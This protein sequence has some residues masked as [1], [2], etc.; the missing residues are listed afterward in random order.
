M[1]ILKVAAPA[2]VTAA[3]QVAVAVILVVAHRGSGDED[4]QPNDPAPKNLVTP[5]RR[6]IAEIL[7]DGDYARH[8]NAGNDSNR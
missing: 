3:T 6:S 2:M 8:A 5:D 7:D 4:T 1:A